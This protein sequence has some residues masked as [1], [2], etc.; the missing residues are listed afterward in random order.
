MSPRAC[1][2]LRGSSMSITSGFGARHQLQRLVDDPREF[3]VGDQHLASPWSSMKAMASASSR[4]FSVLSTAPAMARR[5]ALRTCAG[6]L[7]SMTATVSSLPMPRRAG[8]GE[9]AAALGG[10]LPGEAAVAIDH[11]WYVL[12]RLSRPL[13]IRSFL[14]DSA[15]ATRKVMVFPLY[16]IVLQIRLQVAF[17][18]SFASGCNLPPAKVCQAGFKCEPARVS[19]PPVAQRQF[20]AMK[21]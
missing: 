2:R 18:A 11:R 7:G 19:Q 1:R 6:T 14:W 17:L 3:A 9:A 15:V 12:R 21:T 10:F 5:N 16:H 20:P 4:V 8:R 13:K